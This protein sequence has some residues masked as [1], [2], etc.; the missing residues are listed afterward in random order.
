MKKTITRE[1]F[2]E[3]SN[4]SRELTKIREI[5]E[6]SNGTSVENLAVKLNDAFEKTL[7]K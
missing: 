5:L 7:Q 2:L 1:F 3:L 4:I 6:L